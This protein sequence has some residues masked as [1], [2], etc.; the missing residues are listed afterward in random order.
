MPVYRTSRSIVAALL[1]VIVLGGALTAQNTTR[2]LAHTKF[3]L[4]N[5]LVAILNADHSTPIVAY[6]VRYGIGSVDERPGQTGFA[7]LCEHLMGLGSP[8]E[9]QPQRLFLG[10]RGASWPIREFGAAH[11][12]WEFTQYVAT[13]PPR[14]LETVLWMESDRMA[15]PLSLADSGFVAMR[16]LVR[17]E[18]EDR[19]AAAYAISREIVSNTIYPAGHP[20]HTPPLSPMTDLDRAQAE[21]VRAFCTPYYVPNNA[22]IVLS[23]DFSPAE[24]R[25]LIEKYFGPISRGRKLSRPAAPPVRLDTERRLVLEDRRAMIPGLRLAWPS[26]GFAHQDK[27]AIYA[28]AG[29]LSGDKWNMPRVGRLARLLVSERQLATSVHAEL[30]DSER[31]GE[32]VIEVTPRAGASLST[33]E[34]LVDST[35]AAIKGGAVSAADLRAFANMNA[36]NAV[37]ATQLRA[38]RADTLAQSELFTTNPLA[39]AAQIDRGFTVTPAMVVAVA[40]KYLTPGRVVMSLVPAGKLDLISRP[41]LPYTN[42]TPAAPARAR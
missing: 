29:V 34:L 1:S 23:G 33:I 17:R 20:Y 2:G 25:G 6:E 16:D 7:H 13:F 35:I 4:P 42:A 3:V 14:Q 30:Y 38:M 21:D 18:R 28:L 41:D 24:A 27:M 32:F 19:L 26:V 5:G 22:V 8:N 39:Y 9:R 37:A 31:A 11:T 15:T 10:G 40:K 36:V 12:D